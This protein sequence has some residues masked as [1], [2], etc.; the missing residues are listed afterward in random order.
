MASASFSGLSGGMRQPVVSFS[1]TSGVER[2]VSTAAPM[3]VT[4]TGHSIA[5]ASTAA[6]PKASGAV[7]ATTER[8]EMAS[9]AAMSLQWPGSLIRSLRLFSLIN[10]SRR[11]LYSLR[12]WSSPARIMV[13]SFNS[14]GFLLFRIAI[15]FMRTVCPFQL[16]SLADCRMIF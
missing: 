11:C 7:E 12:P 3:F 16:V 14:S 4:M 13:Q 9:A 6:R 10:A 1:G 2:T 8:C 5:C 15:A